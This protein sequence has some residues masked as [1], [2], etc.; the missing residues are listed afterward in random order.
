MKCSQTPR[1]VNTV[2]CKYS[3]NE[4]IMTVMHVLPLR[5]ENNINLL[6]EKL[7]QSS[8]LS[9]KREE[10]INVLPVPLLARRQVERRALS[11][12]GRTAGRWWKLPPQREFSGSEAY[13][14]KDL[15]M[16]AVSPLERRL[17]MLHS[18]SAVWMKEHHL[19]LNLTKTELLVFPATTT[20]QHDF[21]IFF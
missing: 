20:L 2:W 10:L 17:C 14:V 5:Y 8:V 11:P 6:G 21:T 12:E 4:P 9:L 15:T 3:Y 13:A 18:Q 1:Q 19:Q 16:R 7:L